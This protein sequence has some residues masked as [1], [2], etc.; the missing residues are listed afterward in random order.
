MQPDV[1]PAF[2]IKLRC[3]RARCHRPLG[4]LDREDLPVRC[5]NPSRRSQK[6]CSGLEVPQQ[7]EKLLRYFWDLLTAHPFGCAAAENNS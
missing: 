2:C 5:Y 7:R 6:C 1:F 4:Q 3:V